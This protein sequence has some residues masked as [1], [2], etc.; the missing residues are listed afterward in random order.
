M[1][2]SLPKIKKGRKS[3]ISMQGS[4]KWH[5]VHEMIEFE[6]STWIPKNWK[7]EVRHS[8]GYLLHIKVS[9]EI[10]TGS[11]LGLQNCGSRLLHANQ[12]TDDKRYLFTIIKGK[13]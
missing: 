10:F 3:D 5:I 9:F 4:Q 6:Y 7:S 2:K 12:K 1:G 8:G 11:S 13:K